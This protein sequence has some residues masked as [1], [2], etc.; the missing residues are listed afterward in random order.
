[1]AKNWKIVAEQ[2]ICTADCFDR[3]STAASQ[4]VS[5]VVE[6]NLEQKL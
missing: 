3:I 2:M 1:V 4:A 5:K 6:E